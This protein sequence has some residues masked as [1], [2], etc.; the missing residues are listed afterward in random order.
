MIW[1]N[2]PFQNVQIDKLIIWQEI[3]SYE[4]ETI[5]DHPA[6]ESVDGSTQNLNNHYMKFEF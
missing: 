3:N 6:L 1:R 4:H 2:A 5:F